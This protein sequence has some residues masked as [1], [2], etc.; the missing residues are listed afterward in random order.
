MNGT[1]K[2]GLID[3]TLHKA[4]W[5][6]YFHYSKTEKRSGD[7]FKRNLLVSLVI[8]KTF[9]IIRSF[10]NDLF[11]SSQYE[12]PGPPKET[13]VVSIKKT[14]RMSLWVKEFRQIIIK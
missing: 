4:N 7:P 1:G 11:F 13:F 8:S 5:H 12:N 9:E 6:H 2:I 10:Y 3:T 14:S